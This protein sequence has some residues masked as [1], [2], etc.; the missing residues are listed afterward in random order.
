M[1]KTRLNIGIT[2]YPTFGGSGVVATEIGM[3]M[4]A[5]G[6]TVHF[7]ALDVPQRLP[8][9]SERIY[10]H[11]VEILDYPLFTYPPYSVNLASKMVEVSTYQNLDLLHVHYAVPHATSA[12]LAAQVLGEKAPKIITT[13]HGTDITLVGREKNYLPITRFSIYKSD[14][15]TAPSQYL[16]H[17]TYEKLN[18]STSTAIEVIPNFVD[19]DRF[20]PPASK[21]PSLFTTMIGSCP[22]KE[23]I[24]VLVHVSNFRRVKRIQ[25]VVLV[26][27]KILQQ[28]KAHLILIGDGP[29]RSPIENMVRDLD[30]SSHVCFLGKQESFTEILGYSDL[31]LLPS[32]TES[33]GLAALEAMACG[34]PVIASDAGGLPEVVLDGETGFLST[35]GDVDKM[36]G[37]AL[38]LLTDDNLYQTFSH[39]ARRRAVEDFNQEDVINQ[40][41]DFYYQVLKGR[42]FS[43]ANR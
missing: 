28:T 3:A 39:A 37:D 7:I 13:L 14:A 17:A 24:K 23:K 5:R 31:F 4:A 41:E 42:E 20:K 1:K 35:I 19:P 38:R 30:L 32:E 29:E 15:V 9:F 12:Y 34:L 21:S 25:D 16:K 2:C 40:Y 6:H 10:F 26:L 11:Q 22:I 27:Q 36:A 43:S 8:G 33:F 18:L